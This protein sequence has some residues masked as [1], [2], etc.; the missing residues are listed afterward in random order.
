VAAVLGLEQRDVRN[1]NL[2]DLKKGPNGGVS[3]TR[4]RKRKKKVGS[5]M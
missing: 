2:W 4:K 1:L 5:L 3:P